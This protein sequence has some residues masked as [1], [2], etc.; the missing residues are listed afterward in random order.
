MFAAE[1][2]SI[3]PS[4]L[5]FN[6]KIMFRFSQELAYW[7]GLVQ[8]DGSLVKWT[9]K[10]G[11][12]ENELH[13]ETKSEI[14]IKEFQKG[15]NLL[16]RFPKY[17]KTKRGFFSC[18]AGVGSILF[19]IKTL[20]L[21]SAKAKFRAP[22]FV[23]KDKAFFGA[24]L[25]GIID[26]D[27]DIRTKNKKYPQCVIRITSGF[28]QEI[29]MKLIKE[30]LICSVTDTKREGKRYLKKENRIINGS[31]HELEFSISSKN[32]YFISSFVVPNI[33]LPYKKEKIS[34]FIKQKYAAAG[35]FRQS[36][37]NPGLQT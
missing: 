5:I 18:K 11:K 21:F 34:N 9:R 35:N 29:L 33:K 25:G 12:I 15:L 7:I 26:G 8:T 19:Q 17:F 24:Y 6:M 36:L 23:L 28:K 3:Y 37:L 2:S 16:N 30:F 4:Y 22:N 32:F 10:N 20:R 31:W 14:L 27:G 1:F 13:M